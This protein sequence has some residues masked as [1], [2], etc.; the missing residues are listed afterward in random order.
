MEISISQKT[1]KSGRKSR[2]PR[3]IKDS[4]TIALF[5]LPA[6]VL[7]SSFILLSDPFIS[8]CSTGTV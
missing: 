3:K 7:F 1:I 8:A 4:L 2:S 6:I 5:L